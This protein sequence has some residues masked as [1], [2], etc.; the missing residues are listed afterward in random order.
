MKMNKLSVRKDTVFKKPSSSLHKARAAT[1]L[2]K[3]FELSE[4]CGVDVCIIWYD[5]EGKLVKTWPDEAKVRAMAERYSMLSEEERNKKSTNLSGFLNKKMIRDK[6]ESLKANDN[7]FFHEVSELEDS[8]QS[9]L[10]I[11]QESLHLDDQP[12]ETTLVSSSN[13]SSLINVYHHQASSLLSYPSSSTES[14][15]DDVS[16]TTTTSMNHPQS[17]FSILLYNHEDGTFT[18]LSNSC[19]L[20]SFEQVQSQIPCDQDYGYLDL[21]LGEQGMRGCNNFDL[22][23]SSTI[24][25]SPLL[26]Q[27]QIPN[28]QQFMQT[29]Q[30]YDQ[31]PYFGRMLT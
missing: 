13:D 24:L 8:L 21:L 11:L 3:A 20:P 26:M 28:F 31:I 1:V 22:P 30:A 6:K 15:V 4:L 27:T 17:K 2:K 25:P 16:T 29:Q 12:Q 18:Q 19:A 7:K 10:Q 9:R 14:C 5:R 23:T